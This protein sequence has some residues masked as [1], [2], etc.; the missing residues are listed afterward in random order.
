MATPNNDNKSDKQNKDLSKGNSNCGE[1]ISGKKDTKDK[2][3]R[4]SRGVISI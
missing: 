3:L 4:Q 1:K 2:K